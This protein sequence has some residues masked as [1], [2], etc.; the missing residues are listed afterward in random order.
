MRVDFEDN[1][2]KS[3]LEVVFKDYPDNIVCTDKITKIKKKDNITYM[4][5]IFEK[6]NP[7]IGY[8]KKVIHYL[9]NIDKYKN[10]G[11]DNIEQYIILEKLKQNKIYKKEKKIAR[12]MND[13][14]LNRQSYLKMGFLNIDSFLEYKF[15]V[16]SYDSKKI[17]KFSLKKEYE[18][19]D[20][21]ALK[22]NG[23]YSF[24][25][26]IQYNCIIDKAVK[27]YEITNLYEFI[28]LKDFIDF[29]CREFTWKKEYYDKEKT[30]QGVQKYIDKK[31]CKKN[32]IIKIPNDYFEEPEYFYKHY[33]I[34]NFSDYF[35]YQMNIKKLK[36]KYKSEKINQSFSEYLYEQGGK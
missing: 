21:E 24:Y 6:D 9:K 22:E 8:E 20:K 26:F 12:W 19:S 32:K 15:I 3:I 2:I 18:K 28:T 34:K 13:Y 7:Y 30:L 23:I 35:N 5:L 4:P 17:K 36:H 25:D 10:K 16:D 29:E 11:I 27:I 1:V 33:K 31:Y 14:I